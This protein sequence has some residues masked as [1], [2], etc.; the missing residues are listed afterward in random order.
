MQDEPLLDQQPLHHSSLTVPIF[1][2]SPSPLTNHQ[3]HSSPSTLLSPA[4]S[5]GSL[6]SELP[7]LTG[8]RGILSFWVFFHNYLNVNPPL[9]DLVFPA[10]LVSG[11]V[12]VSGFFILSGF[13]LGYNYG[14]HAFTTRA[15][16]WSFIGRRYARLM[17]IYLLA[18]LAC[19]GME[20]R[21]AH[22]DGVSGTLVVHWLTLLTATNTWWPWRS[23]ELNPSLWSVSTELCFYLLF[24]AFL[25][26]IRR[27]VHADRLSTV[28]SG[29][30]ATRRLLAMW[31]VVGALSLLPS[32][33]VVVSSYD[34]RVEAVM[35]RKP[36]SRLNE[37]LLG[38]VSVALFTAVCNH[39]QL[40][41]RATTTTATTDDAWLHW[42]SSTSLL[43]SRWTLDLVTVASAV[44]LIVVGLPESGFTTSF[45]THNPGTFAPILAYAILL[46]ACTTCTPLTI[47]NRRHGAVSYLL[48]SSLVS[49]LG[50]VS[51]CLYAFSAVPVF[52]PLSLGIAP[53]L[54]SNIVGFCAALGMAV[55]GHYY[56]EKPTYK[57]LTARLP[58]CACSV[59][60]R[61]HVL[62]SR[63]QEGTAGQA[64]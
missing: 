42:L 20:V 56:V 28:S 39:Q 58:H 60:G 51:F 37:F 52:W 49:Q 1:Y 25:R 46:M 21:A 48:T 3:S 14:D 53:P 8:L 43:H 19:V 16:Y 5:T 26:I 38:I 57:S 47:Q 2:A 50:V 7:V 35:Y 59:V 40:Q 62:D 18:Q 11:S 22:S 12:A 24:P 29:S 44:V 54:T 55:L 6:R 23:W 9:P 30:T 27:L 33:A 64:G 31:V 13:I 36:W 32:V 4:S 45:L 15:C 63:E 41:G 17:P 10:A 34:E 61:A